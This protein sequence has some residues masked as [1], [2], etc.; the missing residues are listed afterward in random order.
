MEASPGNRCADGRSAL[1]G[2][3]VQVLQTV[4][5]LEAH[6]ALQEGGGERSRALVS[7][8][9]ASVD[10]SVLIARS[11]SSE[12]G[13]LPAG[14][15]PE[16]PPSG[17]DGGSPRSAGSDQAADSRGRGNAA[18]Q[19]KKRKT[20]PKWSIQVRVSAVQDVAPLDDGL[21]WRKYGQKD[22][23]GAKYPRAYFRCTH[24]HTQGC[25]A[26]KQVQ[27]ADADPL[28]FHVVYHGHHTCAQAQAHGAA[29]PGN[30]S[31]L[32]AAAAASAEQSQSQPAREQG[33]TAGFDLLP[34]P[35]PG[36]KPAGADAGGATSGGF[37]VGCV[38][39][40]PFVSPATLECLVGSSYAGVRNVPDVELASTTNSSTGDMDFVFPLDD[41]FLD[42]PGYF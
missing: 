19:C 24:R 42:N 8:M 20:L 32:P 40:S 7:A 11:C 41:G 23:L 6:L 30:K 13:R 1:V 37:P 31:T 14:K 17:G 4:R 21:S 26:S 12:M 38:A 29:H 2:E 27:R 15:T 36:N 35:L 5:Q 25:H 16:S 33:A 22:I 28:L 34:S 3:L 39:V 18:G 9:R 10:R